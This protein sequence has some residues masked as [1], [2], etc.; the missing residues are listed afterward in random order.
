M[1]EMS[2]VRCFRFLAAL[3]ILMPTLIGKK[4]RVVAQ[5]E[6]VVWQ[7]ASNISQTPENSEYP[8][9]VADKFGYVHVFWSEDVGGEPFDV[10]GRQHTGNSIVYSRWDGTAWTAP[11]DIIYLPADR[12]VGTVAATVDAK[13]HLHIVWSGQSNLYYSS[14]PSWTAGSAHAWSPPSVVSSESA[15]SRWESDIAVDALGN[16]HVTYATRGG[17]AGVYYRASRD[18]G[19]TWE[20]PVRI[21]SP[22]DPLERNFSNIQVVL[23]KQ[24]RLHV[25]WQ[26]NQQDGFGQAVYY[27]RS[28]D[29]GAI[30]SDCSQLG[31]RDPGDFEASYPYIV[32]MPSSEIHLIY[33]DGPHQGRSHRISYDGG[34]SWSAPKRILTGME[35]VNGYVFP[36]TDGV[37]QMYLIVNMRTVNQVHGI[38]YTKWLD[39]HWSPVTPIEL[40][41]QNGG[42]HFTAGAVRLG[43]E[44][45]IVWSQLGRGEIGHI[46]GEVRGI[47]QTPPQSV[48]EQIQSEPESEEISSEETERIDI[49]V[50]SVP[51]GSTQ[52][53]TRPLVFNYQTVNFVLANVA[54]SLLLVGITVT[55]V[56]R[57]RQSSS[58]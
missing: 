32:A 34:Q 56:L 3:A 39:G 58:P 26:T 12:L 42:A 57:R 35:G 18:D 11:M 51:R 55:V 24:N 30:W 49:A 19:L 44:L 21:S 5:S 6:W 16:V 23:D 47:P 14:A 31:Y 4:E 25:T 1:K 20:I 37:G 33:L 29:G 50:S 54:A 48:P 7:Q 15:R 10:D 40:D 53:D 2:K 27:A 38:F 43:K 45:H 52:L 17:S 46:S 41:D 9:I 36:L 8:A 28:V 13:N 22:F